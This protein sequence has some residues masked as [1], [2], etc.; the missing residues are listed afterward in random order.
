MKRLRRL[1]PVPVVLCAVA[2][3]SGGFE[4]LHAGGGQTAALRRALTLLSRPKQ[5]K[6]AAQLLEQASRSGSPSVRAQASNVLA[7]TLVEQGGGKTTAQAMQL[8]A[9]AIRLDPTDDAS[10]F[11]LELLLTLHGGSRKSGKTSAKSSKRAPARERQSP[12]GAGA[13]SGGKG[14]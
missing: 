13:A 5:S 3:A 6:P 4:V 10:K 14:Y 1:W 9:R 12:G 2:L 7:A 8:Y 11:D